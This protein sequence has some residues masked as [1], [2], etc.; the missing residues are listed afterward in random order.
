MVYNIGFYC[1][2][3]IAGASCTALFFFCGF[4]LGNKE[5]VRDVSFMEVT[6]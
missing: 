6:F 3:S 4:V 5:A 1:A 2:S